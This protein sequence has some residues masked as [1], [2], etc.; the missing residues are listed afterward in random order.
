MT[1]YAVIA[2][3]NALAASIL[4]PVVYF[5]NRKRIVNKTFGL[6]CFFVAI[7]SYFYFL[8][9]ISTTA[10]S[11]LF[12]SRALMCGAIFIS[13][14]YF[15][16]IL[17]LLNKVQEK[18]KVLITGYL[19]FFFF[20]LSNFTSFFVKSVTPKLNFNF[21]PD[22]GI[23]YSPFLI[24]WFFYALYTIYLLFKEYSTSFGATKSQ[25]RYILLGTIVGY[26]GGTTNYLLWYD[27][28]IPPIGNWT[29]T[30]YLGIVAYAIVKYRLMDIRLVLG[31]GVIYF[32]T[33]ILLIGFG[34]LMMFLNSKLATPM[35]TNIVVPFAMIIGILLFQPIFRFF[36]KWASKWFYYTFYSYQTV[37]TDLGRRL[38]KFLELDKLSL[39]IVTTLMNTMKLDRTVI[40]LREP[41]DG[42]YQIQKNIGFKEEN[43]ISLVKDNFLTIRLEETQKPLVYEEIS[44]IIRDSTDRE[45][46]KK[47]EKLRENMKR[48]E[49]A[50]CLPL[51]MEEKI[52]GMI[53]LGNKVSGDP[54]SEQDIDLLTNLSNQASIALQNA[55]LY[56]QVQDLSQNLQEKVDFQTKELREAYEELQKLDRAKSEFISIASHQLR[57]PLT[58]IKGYISMM[59]EESYGKPPEKMRKPLENIYLSNERLIKLVNDLLSVSRIESGRIEIKLEKVSIDEIIVSL[60]EELKGLAREKDLYLKFEKPE[61]P[62]PE[63]SV[64]EE[65][66]R[67][68]IL[69]LIENAIRYTNK[70]SITISAKK[71]DSKIQI[72]IKD[73]GEGISKEEIPYLF[74]SFS[75]GSAGTRFWTEGAGLGLYVAKKF[76]EMHNGKIWAESPGRGK[77]STFYIELKIR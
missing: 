61:K 46:R 14:S 48:I 25:L 77:G 24:L 11:A 36:E 27:V 58:A 69:N 68:V 12:W 41:G 5:K 18:K 20:L 73:T 17:G 38:T 75:R 60:I 65:R 39:L 53:V 74:E 30:F 22:A 35:S 72:S 31:R 57:T 56:D 2:L 63:I 29:A 9:Q 62:L 32:F 55:K 33:L 40:L 23:L 6:F 15:H 51:L 70:G 47:L 49:A 44:L 45:E 3:I 10:S 4:G 50:L 64:D 19:V 42:E 21:W 28:P 76:V 7:W 34:F 37:L 59:I 54:Y 66:I 16:F 43:G 13:I 26:L 8:W 52:V 71:S 1:F 67:Q